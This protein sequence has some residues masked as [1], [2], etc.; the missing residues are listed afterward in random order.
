YVGNWDN[1][2]HPEDRD[3]TKTTIA[4]HIGAD[5]PYV[6][7]F[8]MRH[9]L[10]HWVW[11]Q[12]S[13]AVVERDPLSSQ[14]TRLCGTHQNIDIRKQSE[15]NLQAAYQIISQSSSVVLK[16]RY[17]EGLPIEFATENVVHLLG[18]TVEQL[19]NDQLP[20]LNLIHPE[21]LPIFAQELD[22]CRNNLNC[23]EIAHIPYR[24][25]TDNGSIKWVQ[26]HKVLNRDDHGQITGYQGLVTDITRQRQQNSAIRNIISGSLEKHSP[27]TLDNLTVLTAETLT[28]DYTIIGELRRNGD[29]RIL[30]CYTPGKAPENLDFKIHPTIHAQLAAGKT[31][32]YPHDAYRHFPDDD[33]LHRHQIQGL[34]GLPLLNDRQQIFGYIVVLYRHGV[35]DPQFAS[36]ILKLFASQI[37]SELE[38][39]SAIKALEDQKQRLIDAQSISHTGDWQWHWSDNHFTWSDE[40]YNITGTNK[41]SFMPSFASIL[42]QLVYPDDRTLFKITLQNANANGVIDFRH[43]IVLNQGEIRHVHQRGK[44]LHD[45]KRRVIGIQGTMQDITDRLKTEQRLM[46]AKQDAEKAAQVKSE[47]LANMSHEIR[48]PMNAIIGLVELCLNS[49]LPPK[50]RDYL[51]RLET[52]AHGLMGLINDILDFSKMESGKFNLETVPF[53]L[54]EML[55]QVFST[56]AELCHRKHLT[57]MRPIVPCQFQAVI[58]DP[59]R[60]RQILINLIGN[61]IKFTEQGRIEISIREVA[62]TDT[63]TTLEFSIIDT[64]IGMTKTQLNKL[65]RAF[66]QGDSSVSRHYGGTGLGLVISKQLVE[67]MGG[68]IKV[69]SQ[70]QV[71]SCFSFTVNLGIGDVGSIRQSQARVPKNI[72]TRQLLDLNDARILL[73]EDNEVNR[74]V[75]TE[76]LSLTQL[77]IDTAENGEIALSKLKRTRYDCIL[78][79]VQ[80]PKMDGYQTTRLLRQLPDCGDIPVIAMTANVMSADRNRCLQAGMNDF[81][82]KP[83]LPETLFTTLLKWIKPI[84][85]S[86][87][88]DLDSTNAPIPTLYGIDSAIGLL[89]TAEDKKI[90]R[91]IL[92][93]FAENHAHSVSEIE[94]ALA[95][96]DS[97]TARQL[98]HTLKGLAG[99]LGAILLQE[100]LTHLE[101]AL[102]KTGSTAEPVVKLLTQTGT[103]LN[104]IIASIQAVLPMTDRTAGKPEK[105][106]SATETQQQ[107]QLLLAKLQAFDSNADR[108][109]EHLLSGIADNA[110]ISRLG[111]IKA[112]IANYRFVDAANALSKLLESSG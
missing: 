97:A 27:T 67:Q 91:K 36:D 68:S 2:I 83:I 20:Y 108:Q 31:C 65:F 58:G 45:E 102:E 51:E 15:N 56:M 50:Q 76:L 107:L 44:V 12:R 7:E 64:G 87:L 25:I 66:T 84:R 88:T 11:I 81:I 112:Q 111:P 17:A 101:E 104:K 109:L 74:I 34:I 98:V 105:I 95:A 57:M 39:S 8:R 29:N 79:D 89:H 54:D 41:A 35:P 61:A 69:R 5:H 82:G 86:R 24:I 28:A 78:M 100:L 37:T 16:W 26:D 93:K 23:L 38:R 40:M 52:A 99:S 6:V 30:S 73:V 103:E 94:M 53:L 49:Q 55:D 43:R 62:R 14:P 48:T 85:A 71:G 9:K 22:S 46:E 96:N 80:M 70:K 60:L 42:A 10:G 90:Y 3:R 32:H 59:Q 21:D 1:R 106:F 72:D 63:Q 33:W 75:A 19:L 110:L 47:F 77:Q 13:G 18:Y 4:R 92:Q